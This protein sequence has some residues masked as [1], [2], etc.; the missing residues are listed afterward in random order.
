MMHCSQLNI[1]VMAP[2]PTYIIYLKLRYNPKENGQLMSVCFDMGVVTQSLWRV[3]MVVMTKQWP[4]TISIDLF[5]V[6]IPKA[7]NCKLVFML[8]HEVLPVVLVLVKTLVWR[9]NRQNKND[10]MFWPHQQS[11]SVSWS[12]ENKK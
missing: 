5:V 3:N 7:I 6:H 4:W 2:N 10:P 9:E 1:H 11:W 12:L 8:L